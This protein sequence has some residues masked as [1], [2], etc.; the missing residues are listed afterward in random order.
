VSTEPGPSSIRFRAI[1]YLSAVPAVALAAGLTAALQRWLGPSVS[2]FFFLSVVVIAVSA[3]YGPAILA[4]V[5][6]TVMV[7]YFFVPPLYQFEIGAD[8]W[9]RLSVFVLVALTTAGLSSRRHR[10]ESARRRTLAALEETVSTLQK[11]AKWPLHISHD[12]AT[13]V[14][15]V[16]DR[17]AETVAARAVA[18]TW[19]TDDEPWRFVVATTSTAFV[20]LPATLAAENAPVPTEVVRALQDP[21]PVAVR[22]ETDDIAGTAYFSAVTHV[23]PAV[24]E[25]VAH[26]VGNSLNQLHLA[27][28][29][30][31]LAVREDRIRVSRDLHDGILQALTGIRLELQSVA[32][33]HTPVA[34]RMVAAERALAREQRELRLFIDGLKPQPED[35]HPSARVATTLEELR[36]RF[37]DELRVPIT[38]RVA[39]PDLVLPPTLDRAIGLMVHEGVSNALRHAHPSHVVV[40]VEGTSSLLTIIV[41]DDGQGFPF[42]G[43]LE[44]EELLRAN[45]GPV[46]LRERAAELDGRLTVESGATGSRVELRIPITSLAS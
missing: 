1:G 40:D 8:D 26:E 15:Q 11:V 27:D 45:A 13:S 17:A 2:T 16:L 4:S 46:S 21:S 31:Q 7:D 20:K 43:R 38:V 42:R 30:R 6:S 41:S 9:I 23:A 36:E 5:L 44:H 28:R 33:S 25:L 35:A 18:V 34:E 32:V 37:V 39:P 10:A 19:E 29:L 22:F 24:I 14:R 12:F 3:G